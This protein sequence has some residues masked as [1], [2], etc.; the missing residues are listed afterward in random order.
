MDLMPHNLKA[1]RSVKKHLRSS[2]RTCVIHPTGTGKS[3]IALQLIEDKPKARILYITSVA[4]NL[5]EF[6]NKVEELGGR[7]MVLSLSQSSIPKVAGGEFK[8]EL[9]GGSSYSVDNLDSTIVDEGSENPTTLA[10]TAETVDDEPTISYE[11]RTEMLKKATE[12]DE[13]YLEGPVVQ[14]CLYAGLDNLLPDFDLIIIDEFHRAGATQWEGKIN[15]LL[16][17]NPNSKVVGFS[18]TPERMDGRDMRVLFNND[19]ASEMKLSSTIASG[20]LPLPH[21]WLGKIEV[22]ELDENQEFKKGKKKKKLR[23]SGYPPGMP[24]CILPRFCHSNT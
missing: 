15:H 17:D 4:T 20:L 7:R 1:Y 18:A 16:S 21:Y 8:G 3:F 5:L 6:W 11:E 23:T 9:D 22:D 10:A 12:V 2:N 19:V 24:Q 13:S 14:F